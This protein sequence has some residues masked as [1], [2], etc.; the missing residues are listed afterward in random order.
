[1]K[2]NYIWDYANK[3]I[4]RF[5]VFTVP[6]MKNGVFWDVLTRLTR[7]NIPED[8][9]LQKEIAYQCSKEWK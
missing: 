6:T 9:I 4:E 8:A 1:M 2:R 7:G 3:D 5:E